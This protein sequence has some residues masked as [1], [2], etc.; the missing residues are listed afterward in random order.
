[1]EKGKGEEDRGRKGKERKGKGGREGREGRIYDQ[2]Q[3]Q[4]SSSAAR[5]YDSTFSCSLKAWYFP[6]ELSW[7]SSLRHLQETTEQWTEN[8][9]GD[10]RTE[11]SACTGCSNSWHRSADV[12]TNN[13][14]Q[15]TNAPQQA[16]FK[17]PNTQ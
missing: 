1:M 7:N 13:T 2:I 10:H 5:T 12:Y 9:A 3:T 16:G 8:S 14:A 15:G 11:H 6:E 17:Y 4:V